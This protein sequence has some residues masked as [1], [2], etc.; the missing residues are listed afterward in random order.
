[1]Q[2]L[3]EA[4]ALAGEGVDLRDLLDLVAEQLD[5]GDGLLVGGMHLDRVAPHPEPA[6]SE[7][8]V[9]ALVAHVDELAEEA[10]LV[11]GVAD[12]DLRH[13]VAILLG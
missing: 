1:M 8:G 12:P 10:A 13:L 2:L 9:V 11:D 7:V 5:A 4:Q 6:A 3:Q